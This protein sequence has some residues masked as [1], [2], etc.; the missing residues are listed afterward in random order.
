MIGF[1]GPR[2]IEQTVRQ[3]LPEGFQRSE[4]LLEHGAIDLIADR[5]EL[6]PQLGR[7]LS[8]LTHAGAPTR[9]EPVAAQT[10]A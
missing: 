5:R 2:V 4:F 8:I 10:P 6:R 3:I 9:A 7:L 1:A